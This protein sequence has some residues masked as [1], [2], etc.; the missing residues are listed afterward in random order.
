MTTPA[1]I[2]DLTGPDLCALCAKQGHSCCATDPATGHLSFP[3]SVPEWQRLKAW[4]ALA[5]EA[6]SGAD[7]DRADKEACAASRALEL[8]PPKPHTDAAPPPMGDDCCQAWP[9]SPDFILSMNSLFTKEKKRVAQL[10]PARGTHFSLRLRKDG[11]CVFLGNAGCRLPRTVR[12]WYC[13]LFPAWMLNGRPALFTAPGCLIAKRAMNPAHA[14]GIMGVNL[15][16]LRE[17]YSSLRRDW[18]LTY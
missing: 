2:P 17:I 6:S 1:N 4:S 11:A 16:D 7:F 14:V 10:F 9:N 15:D 3:L 18:G 8:T 13:L 5:T 12:P